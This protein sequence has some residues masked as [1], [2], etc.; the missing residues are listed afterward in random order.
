LG[1]REATILDVARE[2]SVSKTTASRVLNG[3]PNVAP[4]TKARVSM[5]SHVSITG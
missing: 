4:A 3:S 1:E 2:A 5:R